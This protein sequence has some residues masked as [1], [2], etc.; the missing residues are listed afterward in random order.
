MRLKHCRKCE[1][2]L[3]LASFSSTM[4]KYC[5]KCK[6]IVKL[7]QKNASIKRQLAR[8]QKRKKK[9]KIVASLPEL[10]SQLQ[11]LVNKY[12]KLRDIKDGCISCDKGQSEQGGHFWPMGSKSALR[13]NEWNI[14]GQCVSCNKFKHGNLLEYRERLVKKIGE[15]KVKWLD[16]HRNDYRKWTRDELEQMIVEYKAKVKQ[17]SQA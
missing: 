3:P 12:C 13:Y 10:K 7:E 17:I 5:N 9:T 8:S 2:D 1:L 11:R 6:I 14:N 15:D 16:A 4:A